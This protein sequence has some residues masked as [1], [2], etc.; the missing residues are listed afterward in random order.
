MVRAL[1]RRHVYTALCRVGYA[2]SGPYDYREDA[3]HFTT[4]G[5]PRYHLISEILE[6]W[7]W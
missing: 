1:G 6:R 4:E 2:E 5:I 7:N 3:P